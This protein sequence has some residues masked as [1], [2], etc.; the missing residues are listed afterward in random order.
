[1]ALGMSFHSRFY[2]PL[3]T[4]SRPDPYASA[5]SR[6]A[7]R[8]TP[9][10]WPQ[11]RAAFQSR[12]ALRSA[13][14]TALGAARA[15]VPCDHVEIEEGLAADLFTEADRQQRAEADRREAEARRLALEKQRTEAEHAEA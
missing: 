15:T 4:Y 6:V 8:S 11:S 14:Q 2:R 9:S 13:A 10:S 3:N 12:E 1:M 7:P 5:Y